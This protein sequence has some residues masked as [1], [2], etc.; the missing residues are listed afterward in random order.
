[1]KTLFILVLF[2]VTLSYVKCNWTTLYIQRYDQAIYSNLRLDN[3]NNINYS[4]YYNPPYVSNTIDENGN[5]MEQ[6]NGNGNMHS[7][8]YEEYE[9]LFMNANFQDAGLY[10]YTK[11]RTLLWHYQHNADTYSYHT[12]ANGD[13]SANNKYFV[14]LINGYD[15]HSDK[16]VVI[17]IMKEHQN[18][19]VRIEMLK[20]ETDDVYCRLFTLSDNGYLSILYE[21]RVQNFIKI[22]L[23]HD[24]IIKRKNN[25]VQYKS[26][27][28]I[29]D[30]YQ[31]ST[32]YK[33]ENFDSPSFTLCSTNNGEYV[34][35]GSSKL[36]LIISTKEKIYYRTITHP[37]VFGDFYLS[38]CTINNNMLYAGWNDYKSGRNAVSIY[39]LQPNPKIPPF[40]FLTKWKYEYP[41]SSN[42]QYRDMIWQISATV[43]NGVNTF[44]VASFGSSKAGDSNALPQLYVF[45]EKH[46]EPL[47][48][49]TFS[50]SQFNT[51][52]AKKYPNEL[53]V[54]VSG[55]PN[56]ATIPTDGG[57]L[58]IF[59]NK[60]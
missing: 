23:P 7:L 12:C 27:L 3:E 2:I 20:T 44:S 13:M 33:N 52:I 25:N 56:H 21:T 22:N 10:Q 29:L 35:S 38:A 17:M 60:S 41:K 42:S 14:T 9:Y 8:P 31:N 36:N 48:T 57:Q 53:I 28:E 6:L 49:N 45:D 55:I 32:V 1:M 46:T 40:S 16:Y 18:N 47:F 37:F 15:A 11:N 58:T 4:T 24:R 59:G 19:N 26:I 39:Y 34:V 50:G 51:V 5:M 43:S 54:A 30:V